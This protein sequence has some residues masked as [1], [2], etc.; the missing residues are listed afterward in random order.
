MKLQASGAETNL[1]DE[2]CWS[3]VVALTGKEEVE[4]YRVGGGHHGLHVGLR[5]SAGR[6]VRAGARTSSAANEGGLQASKVSESL[7]QE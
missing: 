4:R 6:R 5:G 2:T 3:T 7:S 1:V